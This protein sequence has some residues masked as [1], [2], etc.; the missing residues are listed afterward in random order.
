MVTEAIGSR[1]VITQ[2]TTATRD[3]FGKNDFLKLLSTQLKYQNPLDPMK[4]NEFLG[5]MAQFTSLEQITN[6]NTSFTSLSNKLST[7]NDNSVK[8]QALSLLNHY[9]EASVNGKSLLGVVTKINLKGT[10]P[11]LTILSGNNTTQ[12]TTEVSLSD[13]V[14]AFVI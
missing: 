4:N 1:A 6:L 5:Q 11:T 2:Q 10:T 12:N 13:I 9:V 14:S 7:W 3:V 8:T